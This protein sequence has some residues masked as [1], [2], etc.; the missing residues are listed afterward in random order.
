M[1]QD[2]KLLG[3]SLTLKAGQKV[4]IEPATNLPQGGFWVR[5]VK[6][7]PAW[8]E[9]DAIHLTVEELNIMISA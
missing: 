6:P 1:K 2:L 7:S 3:T 5:P 8:G 9:E 4:K